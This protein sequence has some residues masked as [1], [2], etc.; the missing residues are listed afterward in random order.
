MLELAQLLKKYW[1][2]PILGLL[3]VA[4]LD[5]VISSLMTCHPITETSGHAAKCTALK[6]PVLSSLV[7]LVHKAHDHEQTVTAVF[8]FF[9]AIFTGTLWWATDK[10]WKVATQTMEQQKCDTRILQRAY[11]SVEPLGLKERTDKKVVAHMAIVNGGNLPAKNVRSDVWITFSDD[12]DKDDFESVI[13]EG[14]GKILIAPKGRVER[15]S[16]ALGDDGAEAYRNRL[17]GFF[18]YAW[19]RVEYDDGFGEPR[20][21]VFCHR[22]NCAS[23]E[24][25]RHH[26]RHNDGN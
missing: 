3:L 6:G 13:I 8:T 24:I 7:W 12:G 1:P 5:S 22:Y 2:I 10:L 4:L 18:V 16:R 20:W 14:G 15:G 9:L 21:L 25:Y 19:G 26:H 17:D 11:L 23:P